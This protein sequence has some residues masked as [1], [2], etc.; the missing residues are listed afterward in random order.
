MNVSTYEVGSF[1]AIEAPLGRYTRLYAEYLPERQLFTEAWLATWPP[2]YRFEANPDDGRTLTV[3]FNNGTAT[4]R[5]LEEAKAPESQLYGCE[6]LTWVGR[7]L[8]RRRR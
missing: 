4:Y 6:L 5:V 1:S 8:K 3:E 7:E 2:A